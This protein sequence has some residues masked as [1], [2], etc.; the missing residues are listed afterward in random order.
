MRSRCSLG[1]SRS[2]GRFDVSNSG[3]HGIAVPDGS[4]DSHPNRRHHRTTGDERTADTGDRVDTVGAGRDARESEDR[5]TTN[6]CALP[7]GVPVGA[8]RRTG[9][10]EGRA[11]ATRSA[12]P[13]SNASRLSAPRWSGCRRCSSATPRSGLDPVADALARLEELIQFTTVDASAVYRTRRTR[14]ECDARR[15]RNRESARGGR[16]AAV[17]RVRPPGSGARRA[18][19]RDVAIRRARRTDVRAPCRR[20]RRSRVG[21]ASAATRGADAGATR[22]PSV[23]RAGRLLQR[24]QRADHRIRRRARAPCS[25]RATLRA[26]RTRSTTATSWCRSRRAS[27]P[28]WPRPS[29]VMRHGHCARDLPPNWPSGSITATSR[30][31]ESGCKKRSR[32][33]TRSRSTSLDTTV[34]AATPAFA[35]LFGT[36]VPECKER[37][38]VRPRRS[39]VRGPGHLRTAP[40]RRVRLLHRRDPTRRSATPAQ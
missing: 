8:Q 22:V 13:R 9:G 32:T 3:P 35:D 20:L 11:R 16:I 21:A 1:T 30:V 29:A 37:S 24:R 36:T 12:R 7:D 26:G 25:S 10:R 27:A 38:V 6:G 5:G 34:D 33:K 4:S 2:P 23:P 40:G 28:R 17:G 19:R 39:G 18:H 31:R 15:C 14:V